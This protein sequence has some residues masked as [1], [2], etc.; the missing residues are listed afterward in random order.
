MRQGVPLQST[1]L[2]VFLWIFVEMVTQITDKLR[3]QTLEEISAAANLPVRV[4]LCWLC[5]QSSIDY[6]IMVSSK[7]FRVLF[8]MIALSFSTDT[9]WA[10]ED[11]F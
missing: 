10:A 1:E 5:I 9:I 7:Q 8:V 2:Q 11:S 4:R 3:Q 6:P